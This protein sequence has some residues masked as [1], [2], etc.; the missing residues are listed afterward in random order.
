MNTQCL[1]LQ[2]S[3][4]PRD[5]LRHAAHEL[6]EGSWCKKT[7]ASQRAVRSGDGKGAVWWGDVGGL[8]G[9]GS[10]DLRETVLLHPLGAWP[11]V[12]HSLGA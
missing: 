7:I 9:C 10:E 2:H 8:P 5:R 3:L 12:L 1:P 11:F 6:K 4:D